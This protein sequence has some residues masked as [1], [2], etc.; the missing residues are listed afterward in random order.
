MKSTV[1]EEKVKE[2]ILEADRK[3]II[4]KCNEIVK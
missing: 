4:K 1:E 2:K 3:Y